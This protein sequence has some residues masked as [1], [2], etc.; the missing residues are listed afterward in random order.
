M[1]DTIA[2]KVAQ[3]HQTIRLA[4][5]NANRK[6]DSVALLAVSKKQSA[7]KIL[8]AFHAGQTCFGE[9][10]V[11]EALE[12]ITALSHLPIE[13]HFIG[14]IQSNK[15]KSIANHFHWVQSIDRASIAVA[16]NKHRPYDLPPLNVCIQINIDDE[17]T[18]SGVIED[19]LRAL[20]DTITQLPRLSLRGLMC[21]PKKTTCKTHQKNTFLK[22]ANLQEQLISAGY[23]LD[24]LSM[25]MSD[26]YI[27]AIESGS[28]M[29]R[30][31]TAIFGK[32]EP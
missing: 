11:Q 32:R 18:K 5:Q 23:P 27:P 12:K 4:A 30:I 3:T 10:Y 16:L 29:V 2:H 9:S 19:E 17:E 25:G 7:E 31:G 1:Q 15:T 13:W 22:V 21:I 6:P 28:T 20:A 24:T 14:G 26:D 8:A